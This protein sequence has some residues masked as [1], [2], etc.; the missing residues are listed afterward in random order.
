MQL[1]FPALSVRFVFAP[2][3]PAYQSHIF[4]DVERDFKC[5]AY[6]YKRRF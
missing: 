3:L 2:K 1:T 6:F 5:A 4:Q